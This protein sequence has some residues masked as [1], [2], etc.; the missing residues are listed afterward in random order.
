MEHGLYASVSTG[1]LE[2]RLIC[3]ILTLILISN[4]ILANF[5]I[6]K[7]TNTIESRIIT[8][9][10]L[11]PVY[12]PF[13]KSDKT[14]FYKSISKKLNI[15]SNSRILLSQSAHI[16]GQSR[17]YRTIDLAKEVQGHY[18]GSMVIYGLLYIGYFFLSK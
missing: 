14:D 3:T 15:N 10:E 11:N 8:G 18:G 16:L 9:T 7:K 2:M 1:G 4:P 13:L 5:A 6:P 17:T 12:Q